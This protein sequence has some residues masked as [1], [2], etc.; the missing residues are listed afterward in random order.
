MLNVH[1]VGDKEGRPGRNALGRTLSGLIKEHSIK[2]CVDNSE[3]AAGGFGSTP[4]VADDLS[5]LK[6]MLL[7]RA[8]TFLINE[9]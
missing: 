4:Q 2:V 5:A 9:R 6:F 8:V 7:H 1:F 3:K